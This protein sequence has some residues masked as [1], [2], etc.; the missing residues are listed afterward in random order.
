M[1]DS[2][3]AAGVDGDT[4]SDEA[5]DVAAGDVGDAEPG[6]ADGVVVGDE[7]ADAAIVDAEREA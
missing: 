7:P 6:V 1:V 4:C 2:E 3:F 5:L